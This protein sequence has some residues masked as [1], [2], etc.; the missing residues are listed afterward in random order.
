MSAFLLPVLCLVAIGPN[1][2]RAQSQGKSIIG[3]A[4]VV[5]GDTIKIGADTI[6]L[7]GIDAPEAKQLCGTDPCGQQATEVLQMLVER[8]PL[9]ICQERTKD[10]YERSVAVCRARGM[11]LS[12]AMVW[13]GHAMAF[14]R[15]SL[16]YVAE[17]DNARSENRGAWAQGFGDPA[18]FRNPEAAQPDSAPRT[19]HCI[20]KGNVTS[21]GERIYHVESSPSYS[22]VV[23]EQCFE[24]EEEARAAGFRPPRG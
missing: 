19:G 10:R 3:Q 16:D 24:S 20:V 18:A 9:V 13:T 7:W 8:A 15:Y 2:S 12:A 22:R 6:R 5:D 17:E 11:D 23:P 1:P 21:K 4:T 14:R